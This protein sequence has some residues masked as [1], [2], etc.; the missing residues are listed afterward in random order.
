MALAAVVVSC[1]VPGAMLSQAPSASGVASIEAV[2]PTATGSAS[3]A[4]AAVACNRG[5]T[6][7]PA[8]MPSL[9]LAGALAAGVLVVVAARAA[10]RAPKTKSV[11]PAGV[12]WRLL[13][14]PQLLPTV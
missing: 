5:S 7:A 8:A 1:L 13:R 11:L 2:T 3:S 4:C 9:A 12:S 10:R 6:S 14:P